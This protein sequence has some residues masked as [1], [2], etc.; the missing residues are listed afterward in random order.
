MKSFAG[1][2]APLTVAFCTCACGVHT[3][4]PLPRSAS[5]LVRNE[6]LAQG[7]IAYAPRALT[8]LDR[9]VAGF[10]VVRISGVGVGLERFEGERINKSG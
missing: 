3:G 8:N 1:P 9:N 7:D 2:I 6:G 4:F 5:W 10:K